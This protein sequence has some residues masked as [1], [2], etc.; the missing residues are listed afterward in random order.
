MKRLFFLSHYMQD[1]ILSSLQA[2]G[3][4]A[5][6]F[7]ELLSQEWGRAS[8]A[9]GFVLG[10]VSVHGNNHRIALSTCKR[11]KRSDPA[12][13]HPKRRAKSE[14]SL[15]SNQLCQDKKISLIFLFQ[16][17]TL[18]APH[19]KGNANSFAATKLFT[20]AES[21]YKPENLW[22]NQS[23]KKCQLGKLL[24]PATSTAPIELPAHSLLSALSSSALG[25]TLNLQSHRD[26]IQTQW[27]QGLLTN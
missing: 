8:K 9:L 3:C 13:N 7:H 5:E 4:T 20:L 11:R 12:G 27:H 18:F 15:L 25:T 1:H 26:R 24:L 2:P 16:V 17:Q 19:P 21:C 23:S 22:Q 10:T 6:L 14:T